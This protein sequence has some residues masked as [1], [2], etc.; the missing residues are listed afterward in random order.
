[1]CSGLQFAGH[2]GLLWSGDKYSKISNLRHAFLLVQ[3]LL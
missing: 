2:G 3:K 1:M